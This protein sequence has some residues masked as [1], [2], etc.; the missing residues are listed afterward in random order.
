MEEK[1]ADLWW[2]VVHDMVQKDIEKVC[3]MYERNEKLYKHKIFQMEKVIPSFQ[4]ELL[5]LILEPNTL[6]E[7]EERGQIDGVRPSRTRTKEEEGIVPKGKLM[8]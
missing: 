6:D 4:Y 5:V 2:D 1:D 3:K 7:E 8:V